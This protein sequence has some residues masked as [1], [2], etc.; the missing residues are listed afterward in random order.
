MRVCV[1]APAK[2]KRPRVH[3]LYTGGTLGMMPDPERDGALAPVPGY[4][5][6]K[7]TNSKVAVSCGSAVDGWCA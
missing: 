7:V 6:K 5:S 2:H 1:Q 3:I 4:A